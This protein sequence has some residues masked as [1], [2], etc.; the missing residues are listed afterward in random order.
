LS[1]IIADCICFSLSFGN[2]LN[3]VEKSIWPKFNSEP[4]KVG[5][6]ETR[7]FLNNAHVSVGTYGGF[8][9]QSPVS[10]CHYPVKKGMRVQLNR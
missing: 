5:K 4:V 10:G 6:L 3:T 1:L 7:G 2:A 9:Y 8:T